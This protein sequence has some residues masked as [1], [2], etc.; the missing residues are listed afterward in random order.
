MKKLQGD[1]KSE[2][3]VEITGATPDLRRN[4]RYR[5]AV[6][7]ICHRR[8]RYRSKDM[9]ETITQSVVDKQI[10]LCILFNPGYLV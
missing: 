6:A 3:V 4:I 9:L 2:M 7:E 8:Y 5:A 10:L 1:R